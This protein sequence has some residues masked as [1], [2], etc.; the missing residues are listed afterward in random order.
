LKKLT[1]GIYP[2]VFCGIVILILTGLP[3]SCFKNNGLS[4]PGIDKLIH[5]TMFAIFAFASLWGFRA[6]LSNYDKQRLL[7]AL[8]LMMV[9]GVCYGAMTELMQHFWVKGRNGS[10]YDLLADTLGTAV[11]TTFYAFFQKKRHFF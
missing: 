10:P 2:G 4:L 3:G 8:L 6:K 11:G 1:Q 5:F 7:K 9:V